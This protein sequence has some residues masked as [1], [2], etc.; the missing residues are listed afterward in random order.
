VIPLINALRK[1]ASGMTE[2]LAQLRITSLGNIGV[3]IKYPAVA[4]IRKNATKNVALF[5]A[6]SFVLIPLQ[7]I[8]N[9]NT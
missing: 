8:L 3:G 7:V 4:K 2:A 5:N 9:S 1:A 6:L